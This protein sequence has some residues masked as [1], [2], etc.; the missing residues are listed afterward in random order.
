MR[1]VVKENSANAKS[2]K[3]KATREE[4]DASILNLRRHLHAMDKDRYPDPDARTSK[5]KAKGRKAERFNLAKLKTSDSVALAKIGKAIKARE[6]SADFVKALAKVIPLP[7]NNATPNAAPSFD[8]VA[9][10]E[11]QVKEMLNRINKAGFS[12]DR[13]RRGRQDGFARDK[14]AREMVEGTKR[15]RKRLT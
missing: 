11:T 6:D 5:V 15:Q 12:E 7:A 4:F 13:A 1:G 3:V 8:P 10:T 2:G 14:A 9:L